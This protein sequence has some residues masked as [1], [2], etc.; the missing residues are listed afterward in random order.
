MTPILEED[1]A[2]FLRLALE[3][4]RS[5]DV[6][7]PLHRLGTLG[8]DAVQS[9]ISYLEMIERQLEAKEQQDAHRSG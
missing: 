5:N 6:Q 9:A 1:F 4:L 2:K 8:S 3:R 7:A